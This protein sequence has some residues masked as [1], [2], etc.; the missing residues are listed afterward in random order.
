MSFRVLGDIHLALGDYED[1]EVALLRSLR[2]L[3]DLDSG[4]QLGK[5]LLSLA[6]LGYASGDFEPQR[7]HL[8]EA[9]ENFTNLGAKED[10]RVAMDLKAEVGI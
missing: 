2:I 6:Y 1:S 7:S 9:I 8:E 10:L 4:Y 5:T 3:R